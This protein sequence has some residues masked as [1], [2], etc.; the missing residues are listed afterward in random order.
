MFNT[1]HGADTMTITIATATHAAR[2]TT[3][4]FDGTTATLGPNDCREWAIRYRLTVTD[5]EIGAEPFVVLFDG[6][7][8]L[9]AE[10]L[11]SELKRDALGRSFTGFMADRV[12]YVAT[13][14]AN[15]AAIAC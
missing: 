11:E 14:V 2:T 5:E 7:R 4:T 8:G 3:F 10:L 12:R 15:K 9:T 1:A 6:D 13:K